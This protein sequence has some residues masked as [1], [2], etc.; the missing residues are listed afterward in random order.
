MPAIWVLHFEKLKC[1]QEPFVVFSQ[2]EE[3]RRWAFKPYSRNRTK[4]GAVS[5][6]KSKNTV[7]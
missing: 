7:F 1:Y 6:K 3:Q 2:V 4:L 5:P